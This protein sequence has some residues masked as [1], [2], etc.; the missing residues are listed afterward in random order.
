VPGIIVHRPERHSWA[1][2]IYAG[3]ETGKKKDKWLTFKTCAE[4]EAAQRELASHVLAHSAGLG[5]YGSPR[6]R[7]GIYLT[8]WLKRH[9]TRL[10]PRTAERY[11]TFVAQ[12]K[13]DAIGTVPLARL[14]PRALEGYYARRITAG[15]SSTTV[16]HHHRMLHKALRDAVRQDLI[17]QNPATAA[18]APKRARTRPEVWTEAQTLLFLSEAKATS[19]YYP[20][21]LFLVA[22]GCRVG[23][24]LGLTWKALDLREGV[25][26]VEQTLQRPSGGGYLC[27]DPKSDRSARAVVLS[28]EV[29][30]TLAEHERK[31][32]FV[33]A[34]TDGKPLHANNIRQRDVRRLCTKLGLPWRRALHNLRHAHGSYLLQRGVSIKVVQERLGHSTAAFTLGTYAHVLQGMQ[35]QA[36]EA[37]SAM[38][39][40]RESAATLRLPSPGGGGERKPLRIK[41]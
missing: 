41:A 37:M 10:A 36:A 2:K 8:D 35:E 17:V 9:R 39:S 38:L 19:T 15:L 22:T 7:L 11:E 33:F 13:R 18:Q 26:H 12:A 27:K 25:A 3:R 23:E 5:L 4:A 30:V 29:V 24:A 40:G 34:Q 21:Y 16:N 28:P 1:L 31:S 6:E 14:S 20:V 32:G